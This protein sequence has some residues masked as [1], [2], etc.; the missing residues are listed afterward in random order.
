[1][2]II[3]DCTSYIDL[4]FNTNELEKYVERTGEDPGFIADLL[5]DVAID[6][7]IDLMDYR[8]N[9]KAITYF[10]DI[11]IFRLSYKCK[12]CSPLELESAKGVS[13]KQFLAL[14]ERDATKYVNLY[15]SG[16]LFVYIAKQKKNIQCALVQT[17]DIE[18]LKVIAA[19]FRNNT[20]ASLF[21][22]NGVYKL[23]FS[24][25]ILKKEEL[26]LKEFM[27]I[28]YINEIQKAQIEEHADCI[29]VDNAIKIIKTYY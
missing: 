3:K 8:E 14:F 11:I 26:K 4:L 10:D 29:V 12:S 19:F 13:M 1:M 2:K 21:K 20:K 16:K 15:Y 7:G 24:Q 17:N 25:H 5:I 22:Q 27:N 6:N 9:A 23:I 28:S 18:Q